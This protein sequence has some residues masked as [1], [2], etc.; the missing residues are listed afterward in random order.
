MKKTE[1]GFV[2][3]VVAALIMI[4]LSLL[5]IGFTRL[6]QREQRQA[7]DRQLSR[8]ALY[9]AES[10]INDVYK[11]LED[12]PSLPAEKTDCDPS[13]GL[14]DVILTTTDGK[15]E[16]TCVLYDKSPK[17]LVYDLSTQQSELVEF[18]S[19]N[20]KNFAS[21]TFTWGPS[22]EGAFVYNECDSSI[23]D[24][25]NS[26]LI[27]LDMSRTGAGYNRANLQASADNFYLR[28]CRSAASPAAGSPASHA[29]SD[30]AKGD[31]VN[32]VCADSG[33]YPCQATLTFDAAQTSS[34]FF[35]RIKAVYANARVTV[36]AQQYASGTSGATEDVEFVQ[37]QT[38]I[39]VTARSNDILRRLRVALPLSQAQYVPEAA[40]QVFDGICKLVAIGPSSV[41]DGCVGFYP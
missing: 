1:S 3:I 41:V 23:P 18:K 14:T 2:S 13:T 32:V 36:T 16:Y 27:H 35:S 30:G 34:N 26:S 37:A 25:S 22:G 12:D 6:M 21:I 39:D 33:D 5:T 20:N 38:S 40:V 9:V 8:Q 7:L 15:T 11:A 31:F 28:P 17:E 29:Y 24:S 10:G 19:E 4:I